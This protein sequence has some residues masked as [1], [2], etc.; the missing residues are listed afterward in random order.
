MLYQR[1]KGALS[2]ALHLDLSGLGI[3]MYSQIL[4]V[5]FVNELLNV[6]SRAKTLS[7]DTIVLYSKLCYNLDIYVI[8]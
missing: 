6:I 8:V 5:P 7:S 1:V 3:G 2:E 4:N